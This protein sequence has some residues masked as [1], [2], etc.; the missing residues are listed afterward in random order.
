MGCL[1]FGLLVVAAATTLTAGASPGSFYELE[2]NLLQDPGNRYRL[3]KAFYPPRQ[4]HPVVV[5]VKY[6]FSEEQEQVDGSAN[7]S[8][9]WYWSESGFYLIQPLEVFQCT[10]LLFSNLQYR[11]R[12]LQ[13]HLPSNCSFAS[14]E[15]LE[16]LTLRVGH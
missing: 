6:D 9:V 16:M 5:K 7:K 15:Q 10:S 11:S 13:I 12:E 8:L 1:L 3:L 4:A 14:Q 2:R